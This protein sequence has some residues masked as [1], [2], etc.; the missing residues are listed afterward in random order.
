MIFQ[1]RLWKKLVL[2]RRPKTRELKRMKDLKGIF[3]WRK[4]SSSEMMDKEEE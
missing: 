4:K 2:I 3:H 1:F